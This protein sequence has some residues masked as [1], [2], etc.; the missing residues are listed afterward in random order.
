ECPGGDEEN[1]IGANRPVSRRD[2]RAFDDR[3]EI[4]LNS[5][6][7][8]VGSGFVGWNGLVD[9]VNEYY[10]T[11]LNRLNRFLNHGLVVDEPVRLLVLENPSCLAHGHTA[12]HALRGEHLLEHVVERLLHL[13][14]G[15]AAVEVVSPDIDGSALDL[16]L[17]LGV[18]DLL[19]LKQSLK[20]L[21]FALP[22]TLLRLLLTSRS[23]GFGE[24][25]GRGSS[26]TP[27]LRL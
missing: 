24:S 26:P 4:T 19:L 13:I 8:H 9:F 6:G 2:H 3:Q 10:P 7:R 20:P 25:F 17:D 21:P 22:A 16:E 5:A 14:T 12:A 23:V 11:R 1:V 27:R 15:T 18:L